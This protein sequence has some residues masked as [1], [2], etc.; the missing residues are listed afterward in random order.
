ML[1]HNRSILVTGGGR[2]LGR[3]IAEAIVEAGGCVTICDLTEEAANE[4]AHLIDGTDLRTLGIECDVREEDSVTSAVQT[5]VEKFGRLD[6]LVNN[7]GVARFDSALDASAVDR[8]DQYAVNVEGLYLCCQ[9]AARQMI[10]QGSGGAIVNIASEAGKVGYPN[11]ATYNATKAAVISLTR[12]LA[13]EWWVER[14]NVNAVCPGAV[15]TEMLVEVAR[16][17]AQQTGE[18]AD[19]LLGVMTAPLLGRHIQPIEVGR[20]VAFLLSEHAEI[21]RGQSVNV[22]GGGAPY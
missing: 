10:S 8:A 21:I 20:V 13:K 22:D 11:M 15:Y 2:G 17:R 18:D 4:T 6:G 5:A 12:T 14:I 9:A 16:W 19:E 3:G 1:L 7:A